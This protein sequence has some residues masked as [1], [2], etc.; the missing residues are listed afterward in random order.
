MK[1][2]V[3][4]L[5]PFLSFAQSFEDWKLNDQH[6]QIQ[7][8]VGYMGVMEVTGLF[9]QVRG[10]FE[11]DP[12]TGKAQ[13]ILVQ[14]AAK[15]IQTHNKKRDNHLRRTDFLYAQA[16]PW[17]EFTID[18]AD[19]SAGKRTISGELGLR[20]VHKKIELSAHIDG[21]KP[22]PWDPGKF[23]LFM[24]LT[25]KINRNDFGLTW[26]KALDQG[27]VLV[28]DEVDFSIDVEANPSDQ[29]LAFS[30]F[31]L[32]NGV[33]RPIAQVPAHE[34]PKDQI[35]EVDPEDE[36]PV[37]KLEAKDATNPASVVIGFLIFVTIT[38]LSLWIKIK[39]QKYLRSGLEWKP[40]AAE[41]VSDLIML[42]F[43]LIAFALTAPLMGYGN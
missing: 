10:K 31:Y 34:L 38:A 41:I 1:F 12:N 33:T 7:F 3:L 11:F 16:Y 29:K 4:L 9:T 25:G 30:R 40:L 26:N 36:K 6:T 22:D 21:L 18:Q 19:L 17:I 8:R 39:L 37:I 5:F 13:N 20:G 32:P 2:L 14:I 23:S 43:V 42:S 35:V 27:G 15:S 28:A 24:R